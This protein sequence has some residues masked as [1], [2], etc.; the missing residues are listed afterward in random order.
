MEP[1]EIK[2]PD[3]EKVKKQTIESAFVFKEKREIARSQEL[4]S[5]KEHIAKMSIPETVSREAQKHSEGLQDLSV[6]DKISKLVELAFEKGPLTAIAAAQQ[7]N[8]AHILD[9]L[10][11]SLSRDELFHKLLALGKL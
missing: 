4:I 10:H 8:D 7:I 2:L 9:A 6:E 3:I 1:K 5:L 11:D